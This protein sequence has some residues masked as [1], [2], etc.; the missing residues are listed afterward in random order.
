MG[1]RWDPRDGEAGKAMLEE[2]VKKFSIRPF[3]MRNVKLYTAEW[4]EE[5]GGMSRGWRLDSPEAFQFLE[6]NR[7]LGINVQVAHKGPTVWPLDKDAFDIGDVDT[8]ATSFPDMKFVVTH[9]GLP[10][11]DDFCWVATQDKNIYAGMAVAMAFVHNRPRYFAEMMANLLYW[12][13]PD[14]IL[15]SADYA[16]W[17]PK[18]IIQDFLNFEMPEDLKKEYGVDLTMEI[19]KKILGEITAQVWGVDIEQQKKKLKNDELSKKLHIQPRTIKIGEAR[20][21]VCR[22]PGIT[23][24]R[25]QLEGHHDSNRINGGINSGRSFSKCYASEANGDLGELNRMIRTRALRSRLHSMAAAM[26]RS[27]VAP[28]DLLGL[29][30]SDIAADGTTFLVTSRG[31]THRISD[32]ADVQR[33][34]RYLSFLDGL[35][36]AADGPLV[37]WDLDGTRPREEELTSM[38]TLARASQSN[39]SLNAEL[40]RALLSARLAREPPPS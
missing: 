36:R 17:H 19:K 29:S 15:F 35:N 32:P 18:W 25:V 22:I 11:L 4:K 23:G 31:T 34:A 14:R 27:G 39:F 26:A 12:L 20:D 1:S 24:V 8:A 7:E 21:V 37:I 3:Q 38:L 40:C 5:N 9:I 10:R 13:G 28:T 2:Q 6:K 16:H 33:V 30:R